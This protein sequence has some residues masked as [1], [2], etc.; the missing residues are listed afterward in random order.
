M[1]VDI[2][3]KIAAI[4]ILTAVISQILNHN[5]KSEIATLATLAGLVIVLTMVLSMVSSLF[6]S[7]KTM[8]GIY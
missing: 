4:G 2:L 5:G 6:E 1:S 7:V 3:F 8:F